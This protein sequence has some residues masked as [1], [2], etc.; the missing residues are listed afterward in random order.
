MQ[1][2]Y[3]ESIIVEIVFLLEMIGVKN[4]NCKI[5]YR[6]RYIRFD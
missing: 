1:D 5:M 6:Y 3:V 4:K 2:K